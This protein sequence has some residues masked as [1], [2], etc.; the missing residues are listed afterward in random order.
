MY[1]DD[2]DK[3]NKLKM[4]NIGASS[5]AG[6]IGKN[7]YISRDDMIIDIWYK[8][9]PK[10]LNI[11]LNRNNIQIIDVLNIVKP[12]NNLIKNA[13]DENNINDVNIV[14]EKIRKTDI[15][16]NDIKLM[17][18]IEKHIYMCR[19][20]N[21]EKNVYDLYEKINNLKIEDRNNK[22][23][24]IYLNK[25]YNKVLLHSIAI[26]G[27]LDGKIKN[28]QIVEIKN[29]QNR[30]PEKINEY[31]KTQIK[32]YMRLSKI[33]KCTF[34]EKYE[35]EIKETKVEYDK[36]TFINNKWI[37]IQNGIYDFVD[38]FE[39]IFFIYEIQ[40]IF[41]KKYFKKH[42]NKFYIKDKNRFI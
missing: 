38:Y 31:D 37:P 41:I 32:T 17:L 40:D 39:K 26:C 28:E 25:P 22:F 33:Y 18:Y 15:I 14:L 36:E 7:P 30:I 10:S 12:I 27:V 23:E 9:Y 2:Y 13:I 20:K 4:L 34:I 16:K 35:D 11:A 6:C 24:K 21:N 1:E 5:I 8:T 42:N 3:N 19:G 29:R